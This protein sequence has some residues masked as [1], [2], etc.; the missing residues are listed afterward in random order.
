MKKA[1]IVLVGA[2]CNIS[3]GSQVYWNRQGITTYDKIE[4]TSITFGWSGAI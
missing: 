1:I 4:G 3:P 2:G